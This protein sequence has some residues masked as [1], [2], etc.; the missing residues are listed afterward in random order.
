MKSKEYNLY[1][2]QLL[3]LEQEE[4]RRYAGLKAG[5]AFPEALLQEAGQTA[6]LFVQPQTVWSVYAYDNQQGIIKGATDYVVPSL[7]LRRHLGQATQVVVLAATIGD[8]VEQAAT[9]AFAD[10]RYTL[11]LLLDA[12]G[13]T[14]VEQAANALGR[15]LT[16]RFAGRGFYLTPRFSPGYGDWDLGEQAKIVPLAEAAVIGVTLTTSLMLL[17]R[18]SITAVLG[19]QSAEAVVGPTACELCHLR[20]CTLRQA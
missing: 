19:L 20:E 11:G 5:T 2:P 17:P 9:A 6:L 15:F 18:K 12:A 1:R 3:Q 14:L 7:Q 8:G 10:N 4:L 13:T 16:Q